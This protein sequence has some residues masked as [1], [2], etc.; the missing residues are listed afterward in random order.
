MIDAL[1]AMFPS[2]KTCP[3]CSFV[4]SATTLSQ[5]YE[6]LF[7]HYEAMHPKDPA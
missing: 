7:M 1:T 4:A 5:A 6:A 3:C 2:S